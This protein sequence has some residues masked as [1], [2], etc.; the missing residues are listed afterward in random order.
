VGQYDEDGKL[1]L[2]KGEHKK[3]F[4]HFKNLYINRVQHVGSLK[5]VSKDFVDVAHRDPHKPTLSEKTNKL[6]MKKRQK[7]YG[8][9]NV[10]IVEVLLH[11]T[12]D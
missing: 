3:I 7:M 5:K 4:T 10:T 2:K 11:P 8:N 1:L 6:A 12:Q 9:N